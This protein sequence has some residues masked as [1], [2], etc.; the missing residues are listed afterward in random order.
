MSASD[1]TR[2]KK[3]SALR[4][5]QNDILT[6][7]DV[8]VS[9]PSS[10]CKTH[11]QPINGK[12]VNN[13]LPVKAIPISGKYIQVDFGTSRIRRTASAWT[14]YKAF[15]TADYVTETTLPDN[16][17]KLLSVT[18][19]CPVCTTKNLLPKAS[20]CVTCKHG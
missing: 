14:D 16:N 17:G 4:G 6:V 10:T 11:Y 19:I 20:I 8:K 12:D 18:K 3:L 9:G 5:Y 2:M 15:Q 1:I 7:T 13:P